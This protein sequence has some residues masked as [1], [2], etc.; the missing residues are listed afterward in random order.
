MGTR[1]FDG[2]E[3]RDKNSK[4]DGNRNVIEII[5]RDRDGKSKILPKSD[6]CHPYPSTKADETGLVFNSYKWL[7]L[8]VNFIYIYMDLRLKHLN[9]NQTN[10]QEVRFDFFFSH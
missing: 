4:S 3:D 8:F 1:S 2:C 6:H 5:N 9:L 10:L 7:I